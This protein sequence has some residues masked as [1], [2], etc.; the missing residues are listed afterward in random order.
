MQDAGRAWGEFADLAFVHVPA[1]D[2]SC[3]ASNL[4][5]V[6]DVRPV[7]VGGEYLARAFFPNEPRRDRNVLIDG[8]SFT[9]DPAGTLKLVGILRHELG[10]SIGLRHEHTR[11]ESGTCFED[12]DWKPLTEY[13]AFSVM[14]YPQC[15]G[16]GDWSLELT[17]LDRNGIACLYGAAPGFTLDRSQCLDPPPLPP[18][19]ATA[20]TKRYRREQVELDEEKLYPVFNVRPGTRF[21]ATITGRMDTPG[22]PDIYVRFDEAPDRVMR[23]YA[24]RPFLTGPEESCSLDVP[25]GATEAYVMVH[26]YE[27]GRYALTVKYAPAN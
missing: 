24:C 23:R 22:D 6:F 5:V 7:D 12:A 8:S 1:E 4:D 27:P 3:D 25:A 13:D 10:H 11:P 17:D 19:P 21:D 16:G 15:N 18:V 14:H 20:T 9:L 2:A 26:G